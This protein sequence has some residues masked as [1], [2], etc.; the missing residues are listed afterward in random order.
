MGEESYKL[1]L[2]QPIVIWLKL[3]DGLVDGLGSSSF[4]LRRTPTRD[5]PSSSHFFDLD[6]T[7][8][9]IVHKH[10]KENDAAV[11]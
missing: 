3:G 1:T 6:H 8:T 9:F 2:L 10:I 7:S 5:W 11:F 4:C